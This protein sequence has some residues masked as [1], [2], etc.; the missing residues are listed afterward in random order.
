[1]LTDAI[2]PAA[3]VSGMERSGIR[4]VME[5]AATLEDVVHLEVGEPDFPT[6]PHVIE[7]VTRSIADGAV[8][9]TLS[10]GAPALRE[11]LAEKVRAHNG[12]DAGADEIVVTSGGSP[13]VFG[14]LQACVEPGD[15]VLLPD[16]AWPPFA[17][18]THLVGGRIM[19]YRLLREEDT[20]PTSRSWSGWHRTRAS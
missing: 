20:S 18:T 10:R 9:Y 13:A 5:L 19:R 7:A 12:I 8:K 16:P 11:L 6:P 17:M 3:R 2:A 4:E 14:A 15:G 1:M